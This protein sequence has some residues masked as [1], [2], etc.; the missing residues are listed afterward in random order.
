MNNLERTE[1]KAKIDLSDPTQ[2]EN[3]CNSGLNRH[4]WSLKNQPGYSRLIDKGLLPVEAENFIALACVD[5]NA[6]FNLS[7][8]EKAELK[9][10]RARIEQVVTVLRA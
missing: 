4:E 5:Y 3:Y 2:H 9:T 6:P 10:L 1:E 7:D 8:D